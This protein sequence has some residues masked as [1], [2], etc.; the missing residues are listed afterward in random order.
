MRSL[1]SII[2]VPSIEEQKKISDILNAQDELILA[3]ERFLS[4][5][6]QQKRYLMQVLLSGKKR[7][8]NFSGKWHE[9]SLNEIAKKSKAKNTDF[10]ITQVFS[11]SAQNGVVPQEEQFDKE[12]AHAERIDGYYIIKP[13]EFVYNP[14][15]SV[16][17]P[18]GPINRNDTGEQ[19]VMSPLYTIFFINSPNIDSDFLSYYFKSTCWYR[20]MKSVAN[21]GARHDRMNISDEDFFAMPIPLPNITEQQ[22]IAC[23]LSA[24]DDEIVVLEKELHQEK[25][26]RRALMQLLLT[27]IVRTK[28]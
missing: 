3:K 13:G 25:V 28:T 22:A 1:S 20:Y 23:V 14:R 18:C 16:T 7:L 10:L 27:G 2:F 6:Q 12:I 21:Y 5:K 8:P 11:N 9:C 15:I 4:E 17:A 19:G 26:K 24:V